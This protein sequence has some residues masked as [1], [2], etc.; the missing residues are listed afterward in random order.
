MGEQAFEALFERMNKCYD[1]EH[2][3]ILNLD[4]ELS[5][6]PGGMTQTPEGQNYR[7]FHYF[8]Y[9]PA[10]VDK[11]RAQSKAIKELFERKGS[12]M[13]YRVYRSGFGNRGEYLMVAI[14]AES[15]KDYAS[16]IESNN[17]LLGEEWLETYNAFLGMMIKVESVEGRMRPE[18]AY[19]Q[20]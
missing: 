12:K 16:K 5:Y 8:N 1:I 17:E 14:A 18:F 4:R 3:Y 9:A 13:E 20:K 2:D 15:A 19:S 7:K 10:D 6:M 11:V